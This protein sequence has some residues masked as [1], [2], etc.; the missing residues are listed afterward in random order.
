MVVESINNNERYS[1][2]YGFANQLIFLDKNYKNLKSVC[3][4]I[5]IHEDSYEPPQ[6]KKKDGRKPPP[7]PKKR[8][9]DH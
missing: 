5:Y 3:V 8:N 1:D 9:S 4:Y 2:Q 6:K 7:P